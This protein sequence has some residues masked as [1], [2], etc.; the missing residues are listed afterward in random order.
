MEEY[1]NIEF[2]GQFRLTKG[3]SLAS[4]KLNNPGREVG[5]PNSR[6]GEHFC[7]PFFVTCC[8]LLKLTLN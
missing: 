2:C 6:I 5:L 7:Y 3:E 4:R 1:I 8:V